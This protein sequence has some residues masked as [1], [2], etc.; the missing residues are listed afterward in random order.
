MPMSELAARSFCRSL[1]VRL[2]TYAAP[3]K[4]MGMRPE[5]HGNETV[6]YHASGILMRGE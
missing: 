6:L 3:L 2:V 1:C 4:G 5:K